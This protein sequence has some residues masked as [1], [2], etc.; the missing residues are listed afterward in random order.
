MN[1]STTITVSKDITLVTLRGFPANIKALSDIFS[2][3]AAYDINIDMISTAPTHG[4]YTGLSV[5]ISDDDLGKMLAY[6]K[7]LKKHEDVVVSISSGNRKISVYD[8]SMRD[9]PGMA[10]RV[11][12]A[13]SDTEADIRLITTSEVE[14]AILVSEADFDNAYFALKDA[15]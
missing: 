2:E 13:I 15:D 9:A 4:A 10:A 8:E 1:S 3:I 7:E 11:F 12:Q 5:T 6:T 14:I